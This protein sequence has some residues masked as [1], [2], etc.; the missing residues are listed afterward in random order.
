MEDS[1]IQKAFH[2]NYS[3]LYKG[4]DIPLEKIDD[5]LKKAN[6]SRITEGQRLIMNGSNTIRKV[7]GVIKKNP[8]KLVKVLGSGGSLGSYYKC[9][10]DELL[11]SAPNNLDSNKKLWADIIIE[12]NAFVQYTNCL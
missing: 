4:S 10:D 1:A 9:F 5:Y 12:Y 3:N 6:L 11:Q 7:F 2:Q 8:I